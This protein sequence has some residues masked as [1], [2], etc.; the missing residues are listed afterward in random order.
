[1]GKTNNNNDF[2]KTGADDCMM[3]GQER[4]TDN[5]RKR[6]VSKDGRGEKLGGATRA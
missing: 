4:R 1:M 5:G 6:E 3:R 2:I